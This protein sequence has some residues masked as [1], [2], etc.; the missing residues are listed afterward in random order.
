MPAYDG[1][2][3]IIDLIVTIWSFVVKIEGV[4]EVFDIRRS[5]EDG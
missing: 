1:K 2:H 3:L 4:V 5:F